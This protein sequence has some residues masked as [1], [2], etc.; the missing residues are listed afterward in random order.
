MVASVTHSWIVCSRSWNRTRLSMIRNRV[1][2]DNSGTFNPC[3]SFWV[4]NWFFF[5]NS[6]DLCWL[7]QI[8]DFLIQYGAMIISC[9]VGL[10]GNMLLS[11]P[12]HLLSSSP[13]SGLIRLWSTSRPEEKASG[14]RRSTCAAANPGPSSGHNPSSAPNCTAP[15]TTSTCYTLYY[16]LPGLKS[17]NLH[18]NHILQKNAG[19]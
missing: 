3:W 12:R 11:Q 9:K 10:Q 5:S 14:G 2:G 1:Q 16:T 8:L 4:S 19:H 7:K 6:L 18:L 17:N 15:N 13:W